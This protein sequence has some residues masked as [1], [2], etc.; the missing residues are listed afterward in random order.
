M[1]TGDELAPPE[2]ASLAPGMIRDSNR[3]ML[4]ALVEEAGG[5]VIDLG[6]IPDDAARLR[7]ALS[8]ATATDLIITS[9]GVSM[10]DYDVI[11]EVL[12]DH[13]GVEFVTVA[14]NPG[15]P[16][17][18]G[19]VE[20][21]PFFGLPGNPVSVLVS[22][23]QF[24][25]P[26]ILAMQG[27]RRL[28]RP[29][30]AGIAGETLTSDPAKEAYLR[31]RIVDHERLAVL[32]TGGQ[33]SNVLSGAGQADCFAVLPVGVAAVGA[34]DPVILELFRATETRGAEDGV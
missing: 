3:P 2:T 19:V 18:L 23:E 25:R 10:G 8:E 17:G 21:T 28:L 7:T 24:A 14:M 20:G 27:A 5:E 9:G 4:T 12:D 1:S 26:A 29:R 6:T 33:A 15:K 34:G 32:S 13:P 16:L 31:V 11:K 30:V 22:F